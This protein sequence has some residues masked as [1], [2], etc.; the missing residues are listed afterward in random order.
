[1]AAPSRLGRWMDFLTDWAVVAYATWTLIAY[2]G[3]A[4]KAHVS[5]MVPIWL[6]TLPFLAL[7]LLWLDGRSGR[8]PDERAG[9]IGGFT[10]W[11]P[12]GYA[13]GAGLAAVGLAGVLA[14]TI[15]DEA[16]LLVWTVWLLAFALM[17]V[18][19]LPGLDW[20]E[21]PTQP[22]TWWADGFVVL[23]GLGLATMSLYIHRSSADDVFY[24]NRA[25][26][27][28]QLN[29]IPVKD[30]LV[31]HEAVAPTSGA[32]LPVDSFSALQGALARLLNVAAPSVAYY[33]TPPL[34]T[35]L[36]VW[37]VWRLI[38]IWSRQA[39]TACFVVA[40]LYLLFS[41]QSSLTPG[42]FFLSR[43]WQGKVIFVAWLVPT[44]Y[45]LLTRWVARPDSRT[46]LL[47]IAAGV[48][49]IGMTG[50]ATLAAPLIFATAAP[51]L[52]V[53]RKWRA[54][55]VVVA[56]AAIPFVVGEVA[57]HLYG[58]SELLGG[59]GRE[60]PWFFQNLFGFGVVCALGVI[61]LLA[62]PWLA[63]V[64]APTWITAGIGAVVTLL[65]VPNLLPALADA[66]G[67]QG[68]LRR[69]L[70]VAPLP[71]LVGLL[72]SVPVWQGWPRRRTAA[73]PAFVVS[74]LLIAFGHPLW[75]SFTKPEHSY[76]A[77]SPSWKTSQARVAAALAILRRYEGPGPILAEEP[78]M[79]AIALVTVD[80]KAVDPRRW[81]I[82]ITGES[83]K[84]KDERIRLTDWVGGA[85]TPTQ[86]RVRDDLADLGVDLVCANASRT[87]VIS[88]AQAAGYEPAFTIRSQ[89]CLTRADSAN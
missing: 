82:K 20:T 43:M 49:S 22:T 16:W 9:R 80:P 59:T 88:E 32:G 46:G 52:L 10:S 61:G 66:I 86:E 30:V 72:A 12:P 23:V 34:F 60:T 19:V 18:A 55:S 8:L 73:V 39:F 7:G 79:G 28:A 35:F 70:W 37:A 50:S 11:Q 36:A 24:V 40:V 26:A 57:T 4:T 54:F 63:R 69:T 21:E 78:I 33:L 65:L 84:R 14:A 87:G 3:M 5:L 71:A 76:W 75:N 41:A 6:A 89:V 17:L 47:L 48:S 51:A 27:T 53:R 77:T 15:A 42:A 64:A 2:F 31:T 85:K 74:V 44:L 25:T 38:R 68:A 62:A 56:A 81:Y 13:L 29:R 45:F 1:V 67:I 58:L 83:Q